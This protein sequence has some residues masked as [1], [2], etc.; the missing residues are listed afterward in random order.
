MKWLHFWI[1]IYSCYPSNW[2]LVIQ[3]V[4][5][6]TIQLVFYNIFVSKQI[7]WLIISFAK[8]E[9]LSIHSYLFFFFNCYFFYLVIT[10]PHL[11]HLIFYL[12][13]SSF[14]FL[15]FFIFDFFFYFNF[16]ILLFSLLLVFIFFSNYLFLSAFI[17]F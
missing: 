3:K 7:A 10:L 14:F 13:I 11:F 16:F 5:D 6:I 2:L 15:I 8:F 9:N 1:C 17:T 4:D 12:F